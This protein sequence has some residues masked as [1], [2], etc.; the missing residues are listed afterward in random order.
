[1]RNKIITLALSGVALFIMSGCSAKGPQ[2]N[3]FNEPTKGNSN[4]YIYRTSSLGAGVTPNIHDTNLE[5]STDKIVGNVKPNGYI[6]TTITPGMHKFWAKTEVTNE[7]NLN[8]DPNKIY[9]IK[10]Y[11]SMGFLVGHPQFEI[12]DMNKCKDEIKETK[13]SLQK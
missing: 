8:I 12:V 11:I 2:F 3:G 5:D 13:L 9:C 10:N 4:V 6:M 1:M 7:V